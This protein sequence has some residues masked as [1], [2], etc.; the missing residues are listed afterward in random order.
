MNRRYKSSRSTRPHWIE[1]RYPGACATCKAAIPQDARAYYFPRERVL[2]C[3]AC[4]RKTA[5]AIYEEDTGTPF[6][7]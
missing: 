6:A 1:T 2:E 3:E 4:G 5:A 7:C